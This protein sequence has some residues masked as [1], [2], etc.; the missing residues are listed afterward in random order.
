MQGLA[1]SSRCPGMVLQPL[2]RPGHLG[3][4]PGD[5]GLVGASGRALRGCLRPR[6]WKTQVQESQQLKLGGQLSQVFYF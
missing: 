6:L 2:R 4:R 3:V 1:S 5:S